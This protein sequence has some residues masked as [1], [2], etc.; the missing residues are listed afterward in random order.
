MGVYRCSIF[1]AIARSACLIVVLFNVK[2]KKFHKR[3][4]KKKVSRSGLIVSFQL[5]ILFLLCVF[6]R[7]SHTFI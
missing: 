4:D 7:I 3:D 1:A 6:Y 5:G 2:K